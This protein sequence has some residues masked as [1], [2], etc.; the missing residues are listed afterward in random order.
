MAITIKIAEYKAASSPEI[1][2]TFGLGSC[3]AVTLYDPVAKIGGLSHFM[4]P[5][6]KGRTKAIRKPGKFV[7]LALKLLIEEMQALGAVATRLEAKLIGGASMFKNITDPNTIAMGQ[8]NIE[9]A[10][11]ILASFN[12]KI[13]AED[14]GEDYGRS[15][16][17]YIENGIVNIRSVHAG[18]NQ[19]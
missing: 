14:V 19:I 1:L 17:F 9:A 6:S 3:V 16:Y 15:V 5:T 11:N 13:V 4:L 8:R 18:D 12:I 2:Q 7:D 10:R